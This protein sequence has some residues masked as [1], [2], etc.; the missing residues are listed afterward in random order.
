MGL[1]KGG[2]GDVQDVGY[3]ANQSSKEDGEE[4][5]FGGDWTPVTLLSKLDGD[6]C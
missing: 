3:S 4:R 1:G 6:C 2:D 5:G